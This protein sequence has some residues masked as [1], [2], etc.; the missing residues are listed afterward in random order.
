MKKAI[1]ELAAA[2]NRT[3][4]SAAFSF[5]LWDGEVIEYGG[6]PK[7]TLLIKSAKVPGQ[8]FSKGFLGFG[9]AYVAGDLEVE[10]DLQELLRLGLSVQFDE[11]AFSLRQKIRLFPFCLKT[12][13]TVGTGPR[14]Y[15]YHYDL[16][17]E[18]YSSFSGR[19]PHIFLRLFQ[20]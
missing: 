13:N 3:D 17:P 15:S 4:P 1:R 20:K 8:M 10:G 11:K 2:I 7:A 6:K 12:M 5:E 18:F 9:E 14:Q 16:T 19:E